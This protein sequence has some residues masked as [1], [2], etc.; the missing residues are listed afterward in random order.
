MR[1]PA[2][3]LA[4]LL[5]AGLLVAPA[6][7]DARDAERPARLPVT[8]FA[9]DGYPHG[10]L[11]RE[12]R[13]LDTV[14]V[15]GVALTADGRGVSRPTPAAVRL[16][17]AAARAGLSTELLVNNYS[18][19]LPGFEPRRL[20][21]LLSSPAA[22]D[23][24]TSRLAAFVEAG[25]W[26]GVNVDFE[27]VP[28]RDAAGL[29]AF[30]EA[31]RAALPE[32]STISI[33]ISASGTLRAYRDRGYDLRGIAA[34]VDRVELMAYDQH[35]PTWSGPGPVGGLRWQA[36]AVRTMARVVPRSRID[37]GVAG[38]GYTWVDG[39][40]GSGW[41]VTP[42]IARARARDAGV[43]PVWHPRAGE[44]SARLPGGRV[45]WWSDV[46]SWRQ[47]LA[48]AD[49]LGVRGLALWRLGSADPL[50]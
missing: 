5:T 12:A 43:R 19:A 46:R 9:Y 8:A 22:I 6:A 35:G 26:G 2:P 29:V 15:V 41:T 50:P 31:L 3:V 23:A 28:A 14:A 27:L 38:Y 44:W 24:V 32:G 40:Q 34:A 39:R 36:R 1:A 16:A 10:S 45:M 18:N 42:A 7:A 21:R 47:R 30:C 13:A 25:G 48:L 11:R 4:L 37:L 33:D 49:R 17:R 20:H